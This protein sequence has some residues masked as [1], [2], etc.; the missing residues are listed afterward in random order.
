[1]AS[2][3]VVSGAGVLVLAAAI[4]LTWAGFRSGDWTGDA[5]AQALSKDLEEAA[6]AKNDQ[7]PPLQ[8]PPF[9]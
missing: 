4:F 7:V 6:A 1:M 8:I 5:L 9:R 2:L 3:I